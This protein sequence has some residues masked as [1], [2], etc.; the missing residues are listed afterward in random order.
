[1][2]VFQAAFFAFLALNLK[3][4]KLKDL[5]RNC[6]AY[7]F[8]NNKCKSKHR[9]ENKEVKEKSDSDLDI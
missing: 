3:I 4:F 7:Y 8:V 2:W 9:A 6:E 5:I 1:M